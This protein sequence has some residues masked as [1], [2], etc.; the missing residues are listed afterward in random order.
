MT[1]NK[2]IPKTI[3]ITGTSSGPGLATA[4][5][6]T[7]L[8]YKVLGLHSGRKET[9]NTFKEL[10]LDLSQESNISKLANQVFE[11]FEGT[12]E[13][14]FLNAGLGQLSS[15]ED[16]PS[17]KARQM[18]EINFWA[19][20]DFLQ[21]LIP[22]YRQQK[23]GHIIITGSVVSDLHFPFK[24]HYCASKAALQAYVGSLDQE[25]KQCPLNGK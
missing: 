17:S 4:E 24:G 3:F 9:N 7:E 21:K 5:L 12:P 13:L 18:M 1:L 15:V 6:F 23:A 25:L 22:H 14:V 20:S 11:F 10:L 16:F 19:I 8:G 2:I